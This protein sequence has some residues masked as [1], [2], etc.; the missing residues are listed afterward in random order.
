MLAHIM[1]RDEGEAGGKMPFCR[2]CGEPSNGRVLLEAFRDPSPTPGAAEI[3]PVEM[4]DPAVAA[5]ADLSRREQARG[6]SLG[7]FRKKTRKPAAKSVRSEHAPHALGLDQSGREEILAARFP[8]LAVSIFLVPAA[9]RGAEHFP[10]PLP[11]PRP[12]IFFRQHQPES[13]VAMSARAVGIA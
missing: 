13:A 11:I 4:H 12:A 9:C 2:P 5:V 3:E 1:A 8:G 7:S 10:H 6:P